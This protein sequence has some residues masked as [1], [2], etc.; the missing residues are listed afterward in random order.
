MQE[1]KQ[2]LIIFGNQLA[3]NTEDIHLEKSQKKMFRSLV[4]TLVSLFV[5]SCTIAQN[6]GCKIIYNHKKLIQIN[7][8]SSI[9]ISDNP[10]EKQ[11]KLQNSS[12]KL[13]FKKNQLL[14][15]NKKIY[16]FD[17]IEFYQHFLHL[18]KNKKDYIYIYPQY[19]NYYTPYTHIGLGILVEIQN[20]KIIIKENID[21]LEDFEVCDIVNFKKFRILK[22]QKKCAGYNIRR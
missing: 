1:L 12:L 20:N 2:L 11:F 3:K 21:S 9:Y 14:I 8:D 22:T 13:S 17:N 18:R 15:N 5:Y 6:S 7:K 16:C 10:V 19:K 4:F